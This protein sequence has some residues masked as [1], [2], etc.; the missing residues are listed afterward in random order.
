MICA[1]VVLGESLQPIQIVGLCVMY[2]GISIYLSKETVRKREEQKG[3]V[4]EVKGLTR[5]QWYICILI[6]LASLSLMAL[7][8]H[9]HHSRVDVSFKVAGATRSS[10]VEI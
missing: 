9:H 5:N 10:I 1:L 7:L 6:G 4:K 2:V 3:K 8:W